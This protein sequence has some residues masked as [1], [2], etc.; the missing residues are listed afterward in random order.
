[1][2]FWKLAYDMGWIDRNKEYAAIGLRSAV[3]TVDNPFGDIT[4]EEYKEITG[5]DF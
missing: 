1:M 4:P 2:A 5:M 3:I